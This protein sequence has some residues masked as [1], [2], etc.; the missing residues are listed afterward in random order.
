MT[1]ETG[2]STVRQISVGSWF[3]RGWQLI[4]TEMGSFA[5][6]ALVYLAAIGVASSTVLG[7]FIVSGPLTVGFFMILFDKM[8]GKPV[9]ISTIARG[10]DYFV[11][12]ML[13]GILIGAFTALGTIFCIIP[14]LIVAGWYV[15]TPGFIAEKRLDFWQAM[16]AS[17]KAVS[18]LGFEMTLFVILS[19]LVNIAGALLC[20]VGLLVTVPLT[21][22]AAAV[23][24]DDL[25]G[26]EK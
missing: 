26:V 22:A 7:G 10:F 13:S 24:Y 11:A 1:E 5:V 20:L 25:V 6:L 17:R 15:L 9:N 23:A 3:S 8:R 19:G 2:Q 21:F 12:A 14:G 18:G 16:E 4:T